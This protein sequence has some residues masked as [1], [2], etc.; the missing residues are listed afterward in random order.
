MTAANSLVAAVCALTFVHFAAAQM[1]TPLVPLYAVAH[2][3]TATGVGFIVAAHMATA[4]VASIPLG[5]ASDVWGRRILLLT[6]MAMSAVTSLLLPVGD[7]AIWL[8]IIYGLAGLG[9][10]AFTPS[11]MSLVGDEARPGAAGRAYAWYATA[12][13]GAIGVGPFFGGLAAEWWGY[14]GGFVVSAAG[15][16]IAFALGLA[17]P[18]RPVRTTSATRVTFREVRANPSVWA[19]WIVAASGL[20]TQGVVFTF[21]PLL[22][23]ARGLSPAAIG[24]VFLVLGVAN[25]AARVPAGWLMDRTQR[26]APY[27][28]GGVLVGCIATALLPHVTETGPLLAVIAA[29]GVVSGSAGVAI[30]VALAGATT[31]AARGVVMGG[32]STAL[33]LGLAAGSFAFG[34]VIT[35]YGY[36]T[37]FGLGAIVGAVGAVIAALLWIKAPNDVRELL[38]A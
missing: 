35:R 15:A 9:V 32:Y 3:V 33:Y 1:R 23:D 13:Y 18:V 10:A 21:F 19:A 5:R 29:Y 37:G 34:P 24:L 27:A 8:G 36:G 17:I 7:G 2:G 26:S 12:H 38:T 4:A 16:A 22:G 30:G 28:V 25:T 20:L 11:A 14:A 31:P 6:G